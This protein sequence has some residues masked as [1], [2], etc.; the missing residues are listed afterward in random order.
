[1]ICSSCRR[2]F[3]LRVGT[4]R[5]Q[6]AV[7]LSSSSVRHYA[8][9]VPATPN[10]AS[11][12]PASPAEQPGSQSNAAQS[13]PLSDP[14]KASSVSAMPDAPTK[15]IRAPKNLKSSVAAGTELK[16]LGFTKAKPVIKAM[17][18]H[19]YPDWLWT[20]LDG[21]S[22]AGEPSVDLA[23]M[24]KKQRLRYDKAQERLRN[25]I[26]VEIPLHEQSKDLTGPSDD[27]ITSLQRRQE[28]TK[29]ARVANRKN[30]RETNF[31]KSM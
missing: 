23:A 17:E 26:P 30:I 14:S 24:T 25:N 9:A 10:A 7:P 22:K 6:I 16:G 27:A 8:A 29:S 11:S 31:L 13:Q 19:E 20:L 2:A 15:K 1:M 28:V 4:L 18:D 21:N 12:Q 5:K 3:W